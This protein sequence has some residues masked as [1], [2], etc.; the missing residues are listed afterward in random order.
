MAGQGYRLNPSPAAWLHLASAEVGVPL[1]AGPPQ[2]PLSAKPLALSLAPLLAAGEPPGPWFWGP[3]RRPLLTNQAGPPGGPHS[4]PRP[5]PPYLEHEGTGRF[6][7]AGASHAQDRRHP[8]SDITFTQDGRG[9]S[10]ALCRQAAALPAGRQSCGPSGRQVPRCFLYCLLRAAGA[11]VSTAPGPGLSVEPECVE[12]QGE[13]KT[14]ARNA[15]HGSGVRNLTSISEDAGLTS[16]LA[17]WIQDPP[18][19]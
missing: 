17:L 7:A 19:L 16:G 3:R 4:P 14:Q 5:Q 1:A 10:V 18:L 15:R 8:A 9:L 2:L 12:L 13:R 11:E 6:K